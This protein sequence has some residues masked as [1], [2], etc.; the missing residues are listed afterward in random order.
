MKSKTK[1]RMGRP[2]IKNPR[3]EFLAF[4]ATKDEAMAIRKMAKAANLSLSDFVL[5][6]LLES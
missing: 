2:P 1:K 5:K 4:R 3:S 6:K